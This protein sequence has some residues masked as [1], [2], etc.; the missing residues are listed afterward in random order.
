M[1]LFTGLLSCKKKQNLIP[2]VDFL[3]RQKKRLL[4]YR[5]MVTI[6]LTLNRTKASKTL[7]LSH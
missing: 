3:K 6:Y 7:L 1:F 5:L 4:K 2:I